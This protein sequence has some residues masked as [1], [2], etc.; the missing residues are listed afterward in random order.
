MIKNKDM[1]CQLKREEFY[2][3]KLLKPAQLPIDTLIQ[4]VVSKNTHEISQ[5]RTESRIWKKMY[6]VIPALMDVFETVAKNHLKEI[7]ANAGTYGYLYFVAEHSSQ[8]YNAPHFDYQQF[9]L[10]KNRECVLS[11]VKKMAQTVA[12]ENTNEF[13]ATCLYLLYFYTLLVNPSLNWIT[14]DYLANGNRYHQFGTRLKGKMKTVV[15][16]VWV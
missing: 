4:K 11:R 3:L 16:K 10:M 2:D 6:D 7:R 13:D 9:P 15:K 8:W 12:R 1:A 5:L 14:I